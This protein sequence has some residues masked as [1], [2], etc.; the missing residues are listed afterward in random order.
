MANTTPGDSRYIALT[1]YGR[2]GRGV[3]TPVW[4]APLH[5]RLYVVTA[6]SAGKTRRVRATGRVRFAPCNASGRRI[7][8][9]WGEGTGRIVQDETLRREGLAA[10]QRKYGWQLSLA[11]LISRLRGNDRHRV[12]LEVNPAPATEMP[13]P[14]YAELGFFTRGVFDPLVAFFARRLGLS[15]KGARLLSVRGRKS[16]EW[17]DTPVNLLSFAGRRY[18]VAPRGETQWVRN[19]RVSHRARLT[20]GRTTET[21]TVEDVADHDKPPILRAYLRAWAWEVKQ[22]FPGVGADT[23]DDVFARV[24]SRYPVFRIVA[25]SGGATAT[26]G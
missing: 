7:L 4:A 8:G 9:G 3:T 11:T 18:L 10:L 2:D 16:G 21:V 25:P 19:I 17:R 22:F 14:V 1:T 5:G 15:L 24:A 12:I 13:D 6:E 26:D 23:S 20:L